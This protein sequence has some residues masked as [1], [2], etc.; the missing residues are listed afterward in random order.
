M[1]AV[2]QTKAPSIR[3]IGPQSR[4]YPFLRASFDLITIGNAFHRMPCD[5]VAALTHEW[6][7]PGGPAG[8]T[9]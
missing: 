3:F 1:P 7:R 8:A 4:T 5:V 9:R 2:A 6:L